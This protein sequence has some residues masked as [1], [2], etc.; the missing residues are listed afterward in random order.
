MDPHDEAPISR[1]DS[2]EWQACVRDDFRRHELRMSAIEAKLDANSAAT[3]RVEQSTRGIVDT[4]DSW[5]GAMKTIASIGKALRPLTWIVTFA[6]A[7]VGLWAT[8]KH[9]WWGE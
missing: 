6:A 4:M 7:V 1:A 5:N 3:D 2:E 9:N 8:I